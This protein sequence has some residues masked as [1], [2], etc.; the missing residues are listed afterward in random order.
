MIANRLHHVTLSVAVFAAALIAP[1]TGRAADI[2]LKGATCFPRDNFLAQDF[3]RFADEVNKA[4]KGIRIQFVGG[5]PA[6]GSPFELVNRTVQ[7]VFDLAACPGSYY[8]NVLP[9]AESLKLME[10]TPA[11]IRA[12]GGMAMLQQLHNAKNLHLLGRVG[13]SGPFFLFLNKEIDRANLS[14][15]HLRSMPVYTPF[16]LSLGA[17]TQDS[18]IASIYTL[19]EG[20]T[21]AGF[22]WTMTGFLNDWNKVIKYRVEPGFYRGEIELVMNYQ[23]WQSLPKEARDF[24]QQV[25]IKVE[26][27]ST[28]QGE[29]DVAQAKAAQAEKGIKPLALNAEQSERWTSAAREAGWKSVTARSPEFGPKLRPLLSL[30]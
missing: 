24:L 6:I 10:R 20:G 4:G 27:G 19:M 2:V 7:G 9:E 13:N 3:V 29:V 17:T 25:A 11:D 22:G 16:F 28:Q 15:I 23:K 30:K 21:V 26:S 8:Q 18:D 1:A 12:N 14:G 5:A